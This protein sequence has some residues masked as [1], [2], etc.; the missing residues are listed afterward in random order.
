MDLKTRS[1]HHYESLTRIIKDGVHNSPFEFIHFAEEVG[2]VADFDLA[3]CRRV[4]EWLRESRQA[5]KQYSVAVNLSGKSLASSEF[6]S[7]LL[8]LLREHKEIG[9]YLLFKLTESA[10]IDNLESVNNVIQSLRREGHSFCLDDFGAGEMAFHYLRALDVDIVKIDGSY[11][12]EALNTEKDRHFLKAMSSL[13]SDLGIETVA[14][15][16][17]DE[18]TVDLLDKCGI[19]YGQAYLFGK[20]SFDISSFDTLNEGGESGD[21]QKSREAVGS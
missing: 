4:V 19:R 20:P 11:V 12:R 16:I 21:T 10:T 7:D 3:M 18:Q 14:E 15:M 5:G 1:I 2:V 6:V 9:D 13:S 8:D 17:E